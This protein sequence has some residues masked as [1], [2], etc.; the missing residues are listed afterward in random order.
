MRT[1]PIAMYISRFEVRNYK[2]Y[3]EPN[4]LEFKAGFN[5]VTGQNNV[6]KTALLEALTLAFD[7]SPHLSQATV[8]TVGAASPDTS[9][10][11]ITFVVTRNELLDLL[12]GDERN[13]PRPDNGFSPQ[14]IRAYDG[15]PEAL[16]AFMNWLFNQ[17][18]FTVTATVRK[19]HGGEFW[20]PEE[21][22][23]GLYPGQVPNQQR[24][25]N[26]ISFRVENGRVAGSRERNL[27]LDSNSSV[28]LAQVLRTRIY[29]FSAERFN[30]GQSAFG[31]NRV[32]AANAQN[33]PEALNVLQ[34]DLQRLT[35][36]NDVVREILPQIRQVSVRPRGNTVVE[37]MIWPQDEG[38]PRV[39]LTIPL[40]Q[41]GSGVG[42][43]LAIL[44]VVM[45]ADHPQSIIIDEPQSFL[46]PGAIRKLF[47]VLKRYPQHQYILATHS[48]TV[49]S[50]SD[51]ATVTMLKLTNR[52]T[53][54]Q[55]VSPTDTKELQVYLGEIG[56]RLADVFGAD[57]I[58]WV[59][60]RTEEIC[61]ARILKS[62]ARRALMGTVILSVRQTG[63]LESRDAKRIIEIYLSLTRSNALLP[64]A[65][66]F[67]LDRECRR[68]QDLQ[69]LGR[70]SQGLVRFLSRRMYENFLLDGPAIA[71]V[72][73]AIG[74]FTQVP[75]NAEA[76]NRLIDAKRQELRY[77]CAGMNEIPADWIVKIDGARVLSEIFETLSE[78]RVSYDKVKHS[79]AITDWLILHDP[80]K[81]REVAHLLAGLLPARD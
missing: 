76:V 52:E 77:F 9:S 69:D 38:V 81:L 7:P 3:R 22:T 59:E 43:V 35:Q 51:P 41:C 16:E 32:L 73:N 28:W 66:A 13:I 34:G 11:K 50:A 75:I 78:A 60:G 4:A 20:V 26:F 40:N 18:E 48:P 21:P 47:D 62:I 23:L 37:A 70:V 24:N 17:P 30:L 67:V 2:C 39:D 31:E 72:A 80:D 15:T 46:H 53:T 25:R 14:G 57:N 12:G 61:F 58:L 42:Q 49:I 45:T 79:V 63:D 5:I 68:E 56:A 1:L 27:D 36:F 55:S 44:Y 64:P 6:G 71:A 74:G 29:R 65:I 10:V 8:P 33:L 19:R 54:F